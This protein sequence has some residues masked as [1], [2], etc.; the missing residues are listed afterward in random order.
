MT[1]LSMI[2]I[3]IVPI[4]TTTTTTTKNYKVVIIDNIV[5]ISNWEKLR[6]QNK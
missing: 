2:H 4:V 5:G 1:N 3:Y 6:Y